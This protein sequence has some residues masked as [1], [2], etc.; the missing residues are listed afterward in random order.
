MQLCNEG[1]YLMVQ[2]H[3]VKFLVEQ[4]KVEVNQLDLNRGWT[5]LMRVAHM[6]HHT[7]SPYMAVF[8]YL[9]QQGADPSI[10]GQ[11][12]TL[13]GVVSDALHC[14]TLHAGLTITEMSSNHSRPGCKIFEAGPG[15]RTFLER[16]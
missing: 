5:P 16:R 12:T 4:R 9:L 13:V 10:E 6:A 3:C 7:T 2:L 1:L 8:E 15:C 11:A 14:T